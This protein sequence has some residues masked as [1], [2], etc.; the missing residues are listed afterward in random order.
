MTGRVDM[1]DLAIVELVVQRLRSEFGADL[2][3]CW[4]AV[5]DCAAKGMPRAISTS[6]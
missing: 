3:G 1:D 6:W 5:L 2:L 4:R